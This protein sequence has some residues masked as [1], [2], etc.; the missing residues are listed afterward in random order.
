MV[1]ARSDTK[2][3]QH[4]HAIP[5]PSLLDVP[6][7]SSCMERPDVKDDQRSFRGVTS[8][9][10]RV[11]AHVNDDETVLRGVRHDVRHLLHFKM[12]SRRIRLD[13]V[14]STDPGK[15]LVYWR[16]RW[17]QRHQSSGR[18]WCNLLP[19]ASDARIRA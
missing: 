9:E 5:I 19:R 7:P 2:N 18:S 10:V 3:S 4:A 14:R 1:I 13:A 16:E 15:Y 11:V 12:E 17:R 8:D 6:L